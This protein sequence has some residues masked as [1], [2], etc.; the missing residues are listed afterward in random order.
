MILQFMELYFDFHYGIGCLIGF[1]I[2]GIHLRFIQ[3]RK[4]GQKISKREIFIGVI[5][6]T[7]LTLLLGTTLLSRK[8]GTGYQIKLLP[9]WSYY[10]V[11][12]ENNTELAWQIIHNIIAF[13]P[14]GF[15]VPLVHN[16]VKQRGR[17]IGYAV[18]VSSI[19]EIT[20]LLLKC[21]LC[22]IYH[23]IHTNRTSTKVV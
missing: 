2:L 10:T 11:L 13:I 6:S 19:I 5:F 17:L 15:L 7:Y 4:K 1:A 21:G 23:P 3:K 18:L 8:I 16:S 20:Q 12:F 22:E 14:F 9:F